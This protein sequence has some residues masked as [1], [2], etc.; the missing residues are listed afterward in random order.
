MSSTAAQITPEIVAEHGLSPEEYDRV[1]HALG[2]EPNLTEL[3]IFSVMWSEHCSYKSSRIHLKKLP[4]TGPQVICGPGENAGVVDIGDGQA[5]IFKMESHNHP[6]Y[7]EPYQGAAT[8]V[9]G[10]LRDVFTMGARPIANMNA[11]RFG[12]PDH[13]RMRHLISGVVHGIGGY[14]NCV[15]VPTVGGEV[16]FHAAY[17]G[18][19]L[20][21]AMTVGVADTD[22]IFYSAASGVGNPIVYVGSKTGR[23]GIHGATMASADFGED[24][25][26]K[27]P[28]VQVGD[29]FTE[30]LL[31]EA[32][33]ELMAS[34]AIVAIQ[35]MG[36][37][38]LT[39]SSVEMAS[40][41]GVGIQLNMDDVPQR[42]TGMTA[43]EMMLSESQERMLM[44]LQP[45][46]EGFAEAI[47]RK[48]ELDFAVIGHVTD[49]GRMVLVHR[50]ET[51]CDIPLAPLADDAPLY[52][53]PSLSREDYKAW[54]KVEPLGDLPQSANVG[55]DLLTLMAS[56]DIAS[57]RWIWEQYDHMV[58][59]D[60]VQR[61]G[62]DAAVVRVHG[63]RKGIAISTDCTPRYCYA[64]PY[65]G[66]KQAIAECYRNLSAVGSTPLAVTNCLNFANPQR[67]EIM[68]QLTGCLDGMG[69]ACRALDFP[70]VSGNVS[71]YNESKA[72][73]G[74]SAILPTPA[75]GGIGLLAD[76]DVMAT[77]AFKTA[78]DAIWLIGGE[79]SH[80]GQSIWLREIAG[81]EAGDAPKVDLAAERANADLVRTL[82]ANGTASAVHD[83]SDG[84]LL[85]AIAEMA[86]A[87][88]IG[89]ETVTAFTPASAFGE[90]QGR[91]VVTTAPDAQVAGAVR[92]GTVGGDAVAGV[93]LADLRAAHEGF[94]PA[95]MGGEL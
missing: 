2:R 22:K 80:L 17:D 21:N 18:N 70:I 66:G 31:I 19:I 78:G 68:A 10:I 82:V 67:P 20:V 39:S 7:I 45:G 61:P 94:F 29:P 60:T 83:I 30:K 65:E 38:G 27:R 52:D 77:V 85:V 71:L 33:L 44:V 51:V 81:R 3:G 58:G 69:D 87:G 12:R 9:G 35:D 13:P 73:G 84:G 11:L 4:T 53:R 72:T 43:Y 40:K 54:A 79:G 24:S 23:D 57:R 89:A 34:D 88:N 14:G 28:T 48:W 55:A 8:G 15:G 92:I 56:P 93:P 59:A 36:A 90:D 41:G 16:N 46:K 86:L 5:A 95:L 63:T 76:V 74:G 37:A 49:T 50:G 91:Y 6:S 1:L 25:D 75:I 42:E 64:D 62:G 32:C 47:F 26:E